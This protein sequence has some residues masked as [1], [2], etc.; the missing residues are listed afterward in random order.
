MKVLKKNADGK[1]GEHEYR[2][3]RI[4]GKNHVPRQYKHKEQIVSYQ[5]W[6]W[7]ID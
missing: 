1:I 4:R 5:I 6:T 2:T 3:K 7:G